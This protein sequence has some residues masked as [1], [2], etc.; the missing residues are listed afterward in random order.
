MH[1]LIY[2]RHWKIGGIERII[3]YLVDGLGP[4][5]YRFSIVTEDVP[6]PDFQLDLGADTNIY[7]R[8]FS[9]FNQSAEKA[10]QK[11]ALRI[12]PDVA[13]AM[14]SSRALYKVPRALMGTPI[15]VILSEH[16]APE[17]IKET[18][19]G[20]DE[21]LEAMRDLADRV[22]V[23]LDNF[24]PTNASEDKFC[25]IGNPIEPKQFVTDVSNRKSCDPSGN[26][27]LYASRFDLRQKQ[28]DVLIKAFALLADKYPDWRLELYGDDWFGGR[29][30]VAD[31]VEE[32][33]LQHCVGIH[34][35]SSDV[36][37]LMRKANILAFPSAYEGWGLVATEA[38]SHGVPVVDFAD[39]SGVNQ[40]VHDGENGILVNGAV[41]NSVAFAQ[42]LEVLICDENLRIKMG[43]AAP[44]SVAAYSMPLFCEKWD[45]LF[46]DA[47]SL[48]G[49]NKLLDVSDI[50]RRYFDLLSTGK[51]FDQA[52][53][54]SKKDATE[55]QKLK[56]K[57]KGQS[58]TLTRLKKATSKKVI[59]KPSL[60]R[61]IL[62]RVR[63]AVG[64]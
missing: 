64:V 52:A 33:G 18:L 63:R 53:A 59:A 57:I 19:H 11:L 9:P 55:I 62:R 49:K 21:F 50:E 51:L 15:P 35:F 20:K 12:K 10:L 13:I 3:K 16:N 6:N 38:L 45:T 56:K 42:A 25:I 26:V 29:E 31:L 23:L 36:P 22:H 27:I 54:R 48:Y 17:H 44:A 32:H 43:A 7:F 47:A 46:Q 34:D 30:C 14:G 4:R 24:V 39:C 60:L 58:V 8:D 61:R 2:T 1:V 40:L 28:P 5:G 41:R 37:S